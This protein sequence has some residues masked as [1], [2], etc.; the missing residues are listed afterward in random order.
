MERHTYA[1]MGYR[2]L[3]NGERHQPEDPIDPSPQIVRNYPHGRRFLGR[4][5]RADVLCSSSL[6]QMRTPIPTQWNGS[7]RR[8]LSSI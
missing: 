6:P 5:V 2:E 4:P 3:A 7:N 8:L 1:D